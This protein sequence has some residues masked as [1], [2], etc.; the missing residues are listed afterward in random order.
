MSAA[1]PLRR[2]SARRADRASTSALLVAAGLLDLL[3]LIA[4][5]TAW[6]IYQTSAFVVVV[7]VALAAAHVIAA[8][9]LRW[10]WSGWWVALATIGVY[11]L[12][13]TPVAA[14]ALVTGGADQAL[15]ALRGVVTAP[16]TGWK[17]LLTLELPL[18][19]YQAVLAPAFLLWLAV[20]TAALSLAWR[21]RRLW[22]LAP[23]LGLALTAFGVVFGAPTISAP[24]RWG[25]V[26][27][28][29]A[30][31]MAA[32]AAALLVAL[33][34]LVW[35]TLY[36][37]RRALRAAEAATGVRTTSR[38]TSATLGRVGISI[39]MVLAAVVVGAVAAP[40]ALAGAPR[41]VLRSEIDP[42]LEIQ[43]S[44]SPLAEYRSFFSDDVVD[45]VLFTVSGGG[46][47][48]RLAT[49]SYYDGR[50]AR[51]LDP[52]AAA[53]DQATAFV[54]VPSALSAPSGTRP[55]SADITI[56]GYRG[57][58]MPTV[59]VLT[60][61]Q[62]RGPDASSLAD[63][64]FYS[65]S[66]QMA[67]QLS[68]PGLEPGSGYRQ[69][70]AIPT[71]LPAVADLVPGGS[72][73]RFAPETVPESLQEWMRMQEAPAGGQGLQLLIDRLRARGYLSH[74]LT[75]D[76]STPPRWQ[77]DIGDYTFAP[78]RAGHSTDRIDALFS[79]LVQRQN[80]VGGDEDDRLVAAVGD[81]EQFSVAA[82]MIADQLGF[83]VRI[84]VGAR[85]SG[86]D[87]PACEDG[88][89]G[90]DISAWIEV[91]DVSGVWVPIDVTPQW[92]AGMSPDDLQNRDPEVPTEV[93]ERDAE[94]VLPGE[95]DPADAG[96]SPEDPGEETADWSGLWSALRIGGISALALLILVGPFLLVLIVKAVRRRS[97]RS[98]TDVVDR[99]TG[100]WDEYVDAAIDSGLPAPRTHT[101]QELATLHAESAP[102]SRATTLAT[103]ADRSVF[104]V[105]SP[106]AEDS[107]RFW[108]IVEEERARLIADR[109]FWARVRAR[110][111]LRSLLRRPAPTEREAAPRRRDTRRSTA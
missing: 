108:Q 28:T 78:S 94:Q 27:V 96:E 71:R 82:A 97:R 42:R 21:A 37:R 76:P 6:P 87:L 53:G 67:V 95:A 73:P 80:E 85:L 38:T 3:F 26:T 65:E 11:V 7:V 10:R 107:E 69:D 50:L 64:F 52:A 35:R 32:G 101:R 66:A 102:G 18:G 24:V 86:E 17:D 56:D 98:A 40:W 43:Q 29:G 81:D 91:Q 33:G 99:V 110:L 74:A 92:T 83:A 44:L 63:G 16:V 111:S 68:D 90:G 23:A 89:R 9:G 19:S 1:P 25:P 62:F 13:G 61:V 5:I 109:G 75:V 58:W 104:D 31:E 46:E 72:S 8:A 45:D 2:R 70:A 36:Q 79:S 48:V 49:L 59:D 106:S 77:V 15:V 103:W 57:I 41:Q 100:G 34:F 93:H 54:R 12:V 22:I 20:P 55:E 84:V 88:C 47:R 14:P 60:A 4:A 51:V 105:A 30:R 39:G